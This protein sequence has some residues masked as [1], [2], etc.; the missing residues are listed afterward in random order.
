MATRSLSPVIHQLRRAA[1]SRADHDLTDGQL[2]ECFLTRRDEAAF[3][4]LVRRHGPMVLGVCRRVLQHHHDAEEAF[5]ATFLVLARKA[6]TIGRRALLGH[7]LYGVASRTALKARALRARREA[8]ERQV[9]AMPRPQVLEEDVWQDLLPLLDR[10]LNRLPEKYQVPLVLCDLEGKTKKEA[11]RQLGLPEGTVS[12]RLAR[13]RAMLR[14]RLARHGPALAGGALA[15]ALSQNVA[16]ACVPVP[17]VVSTAK[18]AMLFAAGQA[19]TTGVISAK[20]AVLTEG[21]MKAMLLTKLKVTAIVLIVL[22]SAGLGVSALTH[23]VLA[24][25]PDAAP[26]QAT[27][28]PD[29]QQ[30]AAPKVE[31]EKVQGSWRLVSVER[32]GV[33][34]TEAEALKNQ[35]RYGQVE[36]AGDKVRFTGE[37]ETL[38]G[39]FKLDLAKDPTQIEMTL[40]DPD[41]YRRTL[42]GICLVEKDA[43]KLF[44]V[45]PQEQRPTEFTTRIGQRRPLLVFKRSGESDAAKLQGTWTITSAE[46]A[47]EAKDGHKGRKF[48]IA[49]DK[50][51]LAGEAE[52][53]FFTLDPFRKPKAIDLARNE[54]IQPGI[55][56]L[57][58]DTLKL[59]WDESK[60]GKRPTHFA[61]NE[62]GRELVLWVLKRDKN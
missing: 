59:C 61:T 56:E 23:R 34:H 21:V 2:L 47:G 9:R 52:E 18:A 54:N 30:A 7:W 17:L 11:A 26:T 36:F 38:D 31:Q 6:A 55:Y 5:Q 51:K 37:D 1:L 53:G 58:G 60:R 13:A 3:A 46:R 57:E 12:S 15:V 19:A 29:A 39:I 25:K 16:S 45:E 40:G 27:P 32:E 10:E 48:I 43:L 42:T 35:Y 28:Q 22:A 20:V 44:L 49:S 41:G 62:A 14:K 33:V 8:H 4:A 50:M 24:G